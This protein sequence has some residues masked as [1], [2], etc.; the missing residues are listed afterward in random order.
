[1]KLL[2][3]LSVLALLG[4]AACN[5]H[6]ETDAETARRAQ[7]D[8]Q[9][10]AFLQAAG[11][12]ATKTNSGI[13]KVEISPGT[14]DDAKATDIIEISMQL[15][16]FNGTPFFSD[17]S[18]VVTATNGLYLPEVTG[19]I[20]GLV[21]SSLLLNQGESAEFYIPSYLFFGPSTGYYNN[22]LIESN[23]TVDALMKLKAIRTDDQQ[24]TYE[25]QVIASILKDSTGYERSSDGVYRKV[26]IEGT[27]TDMPASTTSVTITYTGK[28]LNATKF[29]NGTNAEF[30]PENM[31]QGLKETIIKM[32]KGETDIIYIPSQL[33]YGPAGTV[34]A[35]TEIQGVPA[36]STLRFDVTLNS[37]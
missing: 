33:G 36:F 18:Y 17:T 25:D 37:F 14:G 29:D 8:Q 2:N 12:T 6:S 10:A 4:L 3:Y 28:F 13:Y 32:K 9:I 20:D 1:M 19:S 24:K 35:N 16:T 34:D 30:K 15:N 23:E 31:I 7:E 22:V 27:G 26:L 5:V 11:K 21:E